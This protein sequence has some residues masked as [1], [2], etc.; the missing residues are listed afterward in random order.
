[1]SNGL[2]YRD[3]EIMNNL[4]KMKGEN[5]DVESKEVKELLEHNKELILRLTT[6]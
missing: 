3:L 1:M 5:F 2:S 4:R 6:I